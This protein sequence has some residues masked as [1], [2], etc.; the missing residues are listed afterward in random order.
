MKKRRIYEASY[1]YEC[2]PILVD[3]VKTTPVTVFDVVHI[4]CQGR[5]IHRRG[6]RE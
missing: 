1:I 3:S 4:S 5:H 6:A 2:G